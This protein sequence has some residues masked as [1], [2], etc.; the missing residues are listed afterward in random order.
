MR[1]KYW[2]PEFED[3]IKVFEMGEVKHPRLKDS[4]PNWL[5]PDGNKSSFEAMHTSMFH[6]LAESYSNTVNMEL[7]DE[8]GDHIRYA[9][10]DKESGLDPLLH[11]ACRAL[12][13]YTRLKR[14]I[15][16]KDD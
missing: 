11:L 13:M 15:R 9:R 4:L 10:R 1:S 5:E 7:C 2:L 12:M 16:H 14:E 3:I 8:D 6:H